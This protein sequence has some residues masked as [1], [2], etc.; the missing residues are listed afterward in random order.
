MGSRSSPTSPTQLTPK[1]WGQWKPHAFPEERLSVPLP[2]QGLA[3]ERDSGLAEICRVQ[4]SLR[5][6]HTGSPAG[7]A[8]RPQRFPFPSPAHCGGLGRVGRRGPPPSISAAGT[9]P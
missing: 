6:G 9:Q 8:N 5:K 1:S 4:G 3:A 2:P 7:T